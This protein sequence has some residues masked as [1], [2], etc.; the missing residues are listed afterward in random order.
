[1]KFLYTARAKYGPLNDENYTWQRYIQWRSAPQLQELVS[2]D[3]GL[4]DIL[5]DRSRDEDAYWKYL[6][7]DDCH[8]ID[9]F[10]SQAYVMEYMA[11]V[12]DFNMLVIVIEPSENCAWVQPD[13]YDF[14]GYE[15]LD[16]YYDTSALTNCGGFDETFLPAELNSVGLID[17]YHKA[18]DIR[19]RLLENNPYE[20]HADTNVIAVW[21]HQ[22]IGR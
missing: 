4:N 22:T 3:T 20:D 2:L 8:I 21:R 12:G 6:L 13:G 17:D 14:L 7:T 18:Y 9:F 19:Q 5:I 1:M 16:Q 11:G 15:L 10:T